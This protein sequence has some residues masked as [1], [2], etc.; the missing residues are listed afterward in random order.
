M[1]ARTGIFVNG[2]HHPRELTTITMVVY[3]MLKFLYE[4]VHGGSNLYYDKAAFFFIPAINL[5]GITVIE[6]EFKLT[7]K[8]V[9]IRK[10]HY[11][12]D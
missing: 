9:P 5:D 12:E 7:G 3:V 1:K 6:K 11:I 4:H 8:I 10:N 2:A